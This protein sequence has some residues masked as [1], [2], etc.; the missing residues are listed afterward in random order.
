MA[1][2]KNKKR[3]WKIKNIIILLMGLLTI[4]G[5]SYYALIMPIKNIYIKNNSI[6]TDDEIINLASLYEYPSF[7]LTKTSQIEKN[8]ETNQY[9]KKAKIKK[10]FKNVIEITIDEYKPI[11]LTK[12]DK[13]I[14]EN[15]KILENNYQIT[16]VPSLINDIENKELFKNFTTKF[17]QIDQNILRQI[18]Q[19][20]YSPVSVDEER[21][22]LYMNDRNL[23]YVTLTKINKL[24]K[25]DRIKDKLEGKKGIVYLDSGDYIELK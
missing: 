9:I 18:S 15:G 20:E 16:D 17:G 14:L 5:L 24:N 7:L 23:V 4:I 2:K 10:K 21:F 11:A 3:I 22:L 6:I 8:L 25:Y 12:D 19:I 13:I 1:K